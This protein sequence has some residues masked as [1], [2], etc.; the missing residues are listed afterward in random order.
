MATVVTVMNMKGGVG[1]TTVAMHLGGMFARYKLGGD[2]KRVLLID[3]DPQ[4]N[5]SQALLP[6]KT[7]FSLEKVGKTCL[8]ILQED[9]TNLDPYILQVPGNTTPPSV[10]TLAVPLGGKHYTCDL[11]PSTLSLMYVALGQPDARTGPIEERFDKFITECRSRYD[12]VFIDCHPAGSLLTKTSLRNSDHVV[13]PVTPQP[14]AVRGIGLML[15]FIEAAR[16]RPGSAQPHVLFNMI[17]R[18]GGSSVETTICTDPR[19]QRYCMSET[20]KRYGAFAEPYEGLGFVWTSRKPWS[21]QAFRNL[22]EVCKE[23]AARISR[24]IPR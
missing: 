7:Y 21:T 11:V 10:T 5:L 22:M 20:L 3:Y 14:Y 2:R 16:S 12:M 1:K 19:F 8:S 18:T 24:G 13:I 4:F 15:E 9:E 23:F 6:A 17:P